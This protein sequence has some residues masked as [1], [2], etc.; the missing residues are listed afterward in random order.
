M[1]PPATAFAAALALLPLMAAAP[2]RADD[3]IFFRSPSGNIHCMIATGEWA[4]ARC[5][6]D[7]VTR[8]SFPVPPADCDL[9]WGHAFEVG[10][11]DMR[12]APACVGDTVASPDAMELGYGRSVELGGFRCSSEKT[13][14]TCTNP[15]GHGFEIAKSGQKVF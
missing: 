15:A 14:M 3:L 10:L 1:K 12:G 4:V 11:Q 5:D 6:L 7:E 9:D 13:G 2:A 8:L